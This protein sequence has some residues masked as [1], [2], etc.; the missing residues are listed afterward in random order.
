MEADDLGTA[1]PEECLKLTEEQVEDVTHWGD[2]IGKGSARI[3]ESRRSSTSSGRVSPSKRLIGPTGGRL[4]IMIFNGEAP[5]SSILTG[6][7]GAEDEEEARKLRK[8]LRQEQ[9][10]AAAAELAAEQEQMLQAQFEQREADVEDLGMEPAS[11][12]LEDDKAIQE[13]VPINSDEFNEMEGLRAELAALRKSKLDEEE[14]IIAVRAQREAEEE[15]MQRLKK[16]LSMIEEAKSVHKQELDR[17][18]SELMRKQRESSVEHKTALEAVSNI[19]E[20]GVGR[21]SSSW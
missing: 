12:D 14:A 2:V 17:V 5:V 11:L 21:A 1:P 3:S 6:L 16:E 7:Y 20:E 13:S 15:Q 4:A 8:R 9:E 10:A 18:Q 19:V